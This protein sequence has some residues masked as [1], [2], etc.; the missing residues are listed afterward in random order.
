MISSSQNV[1]LL[2]VRLNPEFDWKWQFLE[3]YLHTMNKYTEH[4]TS[5][6]A[7]GRFDITPSNKENV[8]QW[9]WLVISKQKQLQIVAKIVTLVTT[10]L[11]LT[12]TAENNT[13]SD[14]THR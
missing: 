5:I 10:W 9:T 3:D 2:F 7:Q 6:I 14:T 12:V 13:H 11:E 8:G 4:G 1:L